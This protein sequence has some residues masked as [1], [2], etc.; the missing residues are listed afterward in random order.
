MRS[1]SRARRPA[2]AAA[3]CLLALAPAGCLV[4]RHESSTSTTIEGPPPWAPAHGHRKKHPSGVDLVFD[5]GLG[6]Y[7]V[8]DLPGVYFHGDRFYRAVNGGW[9]VA[10]GPGGPWIAVADR[11]VPP[12]LQRTRKPGTLMQPHGVR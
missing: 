10:S 4:V 5:A 6:V 1:I 8:L 3:L 12:G 2:I 9:G 11:D 7:V